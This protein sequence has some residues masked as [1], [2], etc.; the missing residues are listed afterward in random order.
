MPL[1]RA[2]MYAKGVQ[3]YIAPT[4]DARDTWFASMRHIAA[5]GRCFVLS[6]NQYSTKDMYPPEINSREEFKSLP[7]E[8]TRGGSCIVEPL[9]EYI[10]EPVFGEERI[11]YGDINLDKIAEDGSNGCLSPP[12]FDK[13]LG[14]HLFGI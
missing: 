5:E 4:A 8:L 7:N 1:A 13:I 6:C 9:G 10:A 12:R 14:V 3:I 2:S 11:I